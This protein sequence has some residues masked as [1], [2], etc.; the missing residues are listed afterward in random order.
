MELRSIAT[1]LRLPELAEL[2]LP[3]VVER[4]VRDHERR[5]GGAPR[6]E[7]GDL[8]TDAAVDVKI[9]LFRALQESLSNAT[10]HANGAEITVRV[11]AADDWLWLR[12]ADGGPGFATNGARSRG[13]LGLTSMRERAELLGGRFRLVS[14]PGHGTM[15]ELC[16]PIAGP[17]V[18]QTWFANDE[19][20]HVLTL[21]RTAC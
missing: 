12:V 15:V 17:P 2:R 20:P 3:E 1:G 7:L 19:D 14:D 8:S 18:M 16:W 11:W 10:R 9:A 21:E 4:A 6:L 5:S 13:R